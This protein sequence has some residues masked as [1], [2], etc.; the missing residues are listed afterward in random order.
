MQKRAN[1]LKKICPFEKNDISN[2]LESQKPVIDS[3][4]QQSRAVTDLLE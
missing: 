4:D 3:R 1:L 2:D